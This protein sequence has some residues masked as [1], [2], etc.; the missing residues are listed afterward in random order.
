MQIAVGYE[1]ICELPQP[2]P[3]LL[4]VHT[5]YSR[6]SDLVVVDSLV[7]V[8]S[9]P[10]AS[11]AGPRSAGTRGSYRSASQLMPSSSRTSTLARRAGR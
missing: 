1:F 6:A 8:P 3:M 4:T 10:V 11:T 2:T 5:H 7:T 9:V